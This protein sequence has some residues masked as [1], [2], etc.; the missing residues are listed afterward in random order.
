MA[1]TDSRTRT[2]LA[3]L[4]AF[5]V[6]TACTTAVAGVPIPVGAPAAADTAA[7]VRPY[8]GSGSPTLTMPSSVPT[9]STLKSTT[10]A[11]S[12]PPLPTTWPADSV[13]FP[14]K[15]RRISEFAESDDDAARHEGRRLAEWVV[16]PTHVGPEYYNL[17]EPTGPIGDDDD[18]QG[19]LPV[20]VDAAAVTDRGFLTGFSSARES[21]DNN[22]LA[23]A[24]LVFDDAK[25]AEA[26]AIAMAKPTYATQGWSS[27]DVPGAIGEIW[28][29]EADE[30]QGG[31]GVLAQDRFVI[32]VQSQHFGELIDLEPLM[33]RALK[34]QRVL[35][36]GYSPKPRA[37]LAKVPLD[38]D[39]LMARTLPYTDD[40]DLQ[41][42]GVY[43][44]DAHVHNSID[45]MY[46]TKWLD[47]AGVD[48]VAEGRATVYR[49]AD[50][51]AAEG[52]ADFFAE[53]VSG[54][55]LEPVD[56]AQV[57]D[58]VQCYADE[59]WHYGYCIVVVGRFVAEYWS[60]DRLE[61]AHSITAQA[62][63]LAGDW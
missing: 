48:L 32:L 29:D 57:G 46:S 27:S 47:N 24:V 11:T 43:S 1:V 58:R 22:V 62:A 40:S 56:G 44:P 61:M 8:P 63:L 60:D 37:D 39:G 16:V 36:K 23:I 15:P 41:W 52:L 51:D 38:P 7:G 30:E 50:N 33:V 17:V 34:Q 10:S 3:A 45:P 20:A 6:L 14:T 25:G 53:W 19:V 26:A 9:S 31:T 42:Q 21:D 4:A 13:H 18:L 35:L 2:G 55:D 49:T 12:T 5:A 54:G 59:D 28:G